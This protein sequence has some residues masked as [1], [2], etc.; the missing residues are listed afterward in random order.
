[1][2]KKDLLYL[3]TVG[4]VGLGMYLYLQK[5]P[6][7]PPNGA[8]CTSDINCKLG[9]FCF[10]GVCIPY[11]R[12][13]INHLDYVCHPFEESLE[14]TNFS[15]TN[16]DEHGF[17]FYYRSVVQIQDRISGNIETYYSGTKFI[18]IPGKGVF[19]IPPYKVMMPTGFELVIINYAQ[20]D[21]WFEG[22]LG[23]VKWIET[24]VPCPIF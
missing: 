17:T 8:G 6:S 10:G 12:P 11:K 9:E 19:N 20:T 1:M 21:L 15:C 18:G 14:V 13:I 2:E 4:A 24:N 7:P 3:L 16:L 23:S 5:Q 22:M